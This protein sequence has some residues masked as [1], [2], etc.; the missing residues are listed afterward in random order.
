MKSI[1]AQKWI[2]WIIGGTG[3]CSPGSLSSLPTC[4]FPQLTWPIAGEST[5]KFW[6]GNCSA[7]ALIEVQ[8][9]RAEREFPPNKKFQHNNTLLLLSS[10]FS[11]S[12]EWGGDSRPNNSDQS[13]LPKKCTREH[14]SDKQNGQRQE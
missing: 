1:I 3:A 4:R 11:H 9:F 5:D 14:V 2:Q 7:T 12:V 6:A 13:Y 8:G 10:F